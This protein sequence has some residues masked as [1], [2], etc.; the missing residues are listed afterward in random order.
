MNEAIEVELL[1]CILAVCGQ[2]RNGVRVQRNRQGRWVHPYTAEE[3][4]EYDWKTLGPRC[5]SSALRWRWIRRR[6]EL[7]QLA[8]IEELE[9]ELEKA[10]RQARRTLYWARGWR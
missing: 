7:R 1:Q 8:V 9:K 2:C 4:A 10:L 3:K 5:Q 6:E